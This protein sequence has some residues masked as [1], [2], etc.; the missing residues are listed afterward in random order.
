MLKMNTD[1]YPSDLIETVV[2]LKSRKSCIKCR[3]VRP[4]KR[5]TC[6]SCIKRRRQ[7]YINCCSIFGQQWQLKVHLIISWEWRKQFEDSWPIVIK[8]M[9]KLSKLM[10]GRRVGK[11]I[12]VISVG[13]RGCPHVHLLVSTATQAKIL[14]IIEKAWSQNKVKFEVKSIFDLDGISGYFFDENFLL[15]QNDLNR[16]KGTRLVSASRPMPCCFPSFKQE[17]QFERISSEYLKELPM[18]STDFDNLIKLNKF[19]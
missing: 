8:S 3:P 4:C 7:F 19:K 6:E 15:S 16:I 5:M 2:T 18:N 12:R 13:S 14:R 17:K 1:S 10:A 11:Y 9:S